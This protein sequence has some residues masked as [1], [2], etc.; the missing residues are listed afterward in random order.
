MGKVKRDGMGMEQEKSAP[1]PGA[2]L[3]MQA[4][5]VRTLCRELKAQNGEMIAA[6]QKGLTDPEQA[7]NLLRGI[8]DTA[9]AQQELLKVLEDMAGGL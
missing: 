3:R 6:A 9:R 1:K 2:A 8:G 5:F 4:E 7:V